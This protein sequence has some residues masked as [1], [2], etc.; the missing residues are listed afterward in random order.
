MI[1]VSIPTTYIDLIPSAEVDAGEVFCGSL[2]SPVSNDGMKGL[3]KVVRRRSD[4][5]V[6]I[7]S[8]LQRCSQFAEWVA[9]KHDLPLH[10]DKAF[11]EMDF[12][13]WEGCLPHEIP[14]EDMK[15]LASWWSDPTSVQPPKGESFDQ[16]KQRVMKGWEALIEK[17]KNKRLLLITHPGVLRVVLSETLGMPGSHFFS[18]HIEHGACSKVQVV[19]DEGGEWAS[20]VAHGCSG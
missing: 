11:R 2:D 5:D 15:S 14:Q 1:P 10:E 8:P 6:V 19:H 7:T 4:W 17:H 9:K 13:D 16:F 12:G 20:L 18:I 3:K